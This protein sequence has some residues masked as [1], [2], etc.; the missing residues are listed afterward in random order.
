M[1]PAGEYLWGRFCPVP[2]VWVWGQLAVGAAGCLTP[3]NTSLLILRHLLLNPK[4]FWSHRTAVLFYLSPRLRVDLLKLP[5]S[6]LDGQSRHRDRCDRVFTTNAGG[7]YLTEELHQS[8]ISLSVQEDLIADEGQLEARWWRGWW[9]DDC[10]QKAA[11]PAVRK[12]LKRI[13]WNFCCSW[14]NCLLSS[15]G[16]RLVQW[17]ESCITGCDLLMGRCHTLHTPEQPLS[18]AFRLPRDDLVNFD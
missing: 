18:A 11:D 3:A 2:H 13:A 4:G 1:A 5:R 12:H 15:G 10:G 7:R 6:H 8:T 16:K 17:F 9:W 14:A